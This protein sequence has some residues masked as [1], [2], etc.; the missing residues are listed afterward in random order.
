[1]ADQ[2]GE[3]FQLLPIL[4]SEM[5]P[6]KMKMMTKALERTTA[7][8]AMTVMM[9]KT[10]KKTWTMPSIV[11]WT[12]MSWL[13]SM[14]TIKLTKRKSTKSDSIFNIYLNLIIEYL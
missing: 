3:E 9:V 10:A 14:E 2:E 1:M 5:I 6:M 11:M 12:R 4:S 7:R 13:T 8:I